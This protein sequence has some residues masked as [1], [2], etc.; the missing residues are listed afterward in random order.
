MKIF[1]IANAI[2][3]KLVMLGVESV[4]ASLVIFVGN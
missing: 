3:E 1:V 4:L 2:L